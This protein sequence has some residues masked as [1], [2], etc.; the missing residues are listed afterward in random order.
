MLQ[1]FGAIILSENCSNNFRRN[2]RKSSLIRRKAK[3]LSTFGKDNSSHT[4]VHESCNSVDMTSTVPGHR[5]CSVY[6]LCDKGNKILVS[7]KTTAFIGAVNCVIAHLLVLAGL[8]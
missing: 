6:N 3:S 7:M 8:G 4:T 5:M 1:L 2:S